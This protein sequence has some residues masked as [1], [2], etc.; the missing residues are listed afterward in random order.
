MIAIMTKRRFAVIILFV[1]F[2]FSLF[3]CEGNRSEGLQDDTVGGRTESVNGI[4]IQNVPTDSA[5]PEDVMNIIRYY[6]AVRRQSLSD[7]FNLD[8][9]SNTLLAKDNSIKEKINKNILKRE[10]ERIYEVQRY[11]V[12]GSGTDYYAGC[13]LDYHCDYYDHYTKDDKLYVV[14]TE[15]INYTEE[16]GTIATSVGIG[17]TKEFINDGDSYYF[18]NDSYTDADIT[19]TKVDENGTVTKGLLYPEIDLKAVISAAEKNVLYEY[20]DG[21]LY[22]TSGVFDRDFFRDFEHRTETVS[23]IAEDGV[24]FVDIMGGAFH[25]YENCENIDFSHA[26]SSSLTSLGGLFERCGKLTNVNLSGWDT[27]NVTTMASMFNQCT[28]LKSVDLSGFDTSNVTDMQSMFMKCRS[29]ESLDLSGFDTS[30]TVNMEFM[31]SDCTSLTDLDISGFDTS[32]VVNMTGMFTRC[33]GL[34]VLPDWYT[35]IT[36]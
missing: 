27:S 16:D 15:F 13:D 6:F 35:D 10:D 12:L 29:L 25:E 34:T 9:N 32:K 28:S 23:I 11:Y 33:E 21:V 7:A 3:G 4:E 2:L 31:F 30:N 8:N 22:L 5:I 19:G 18:N 17:H 36:G 1:L 24:R 20:T 14:V 26:D